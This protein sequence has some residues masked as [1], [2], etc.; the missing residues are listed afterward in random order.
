M[1]AD[2]G[3]AMSTNGEPH[4]TSAATATPVKRKRSIQD[5]KSGPEST[6]ASRES[7]N[8]HETLRSLVDLL[9]KY[10]LSKRHSKQG[11]P[12][13]NRH[14][15]EL[16]L[17]SCPFPATT[18]K[19]RTKRAKVSN[20]QD[21]SSVQ[22]R[23]KSDHYNTLQEFLAD[24][25]K[26][27]GAVIE[28]TQNQSNGNKADGT[29]LTEVVNRIA[30]FKKHMNGLVGQSFVNQTEVKTEAVDDDGDSQ[31]HSTVSNVGARE[32]KQALTFFGGSQ[33][34]PK[35]LFSSLQKSVKVPL[36][37]S[38][39]DVKKFV[40]VQEELREG[41]LPNGIT[42][43]KVIPYNLNANPKSTKRTFGEVFAP[44]AGL[45]QLEA[46]RRRTQRGTT[47][48]WIDPFDLLMD[49]KSYLGDRS[50][51]SL[52]PLPSGQWLQYG[53]VTSSP[54]YWARVEKHH[55]EGDI[56]SKHG[57]P[58][59]WTGDDSSVLQGVY[60]SFAPSYDSSGSIV[61]LDSKDMVWWGKRGAKRVRTL[62][63]LPN[64]DEEVTSVQPGSIGDLDESALDELVRSF[65]PDTVNDFINDNQTS[66]E[67]DPESREVEETLAEISDLLDTLSSYHR[68]RNLT[69]PLSA[70]DKTDSTETSAPD[71]V[72]PNTPSDAEQAIYETLKTTLMT[73]ISGLPPYAVAKLDGDQLEALNISQRIVVET[74][75]YC[76]TMERDDFTL[77][78]ERVAA[79]AAQSNAANRT[80]TPSASRPSNLGS[81]SVYNQRA[82]VSNP[83]VPQSQFQMPQHGRQPSATG[84]YTPNLSGSR[85]PGT[86]SQRSSYPAQ[87]SSQFSQANNV[88]Q[89]QRPG[90][91]GYNSYSAQQGQGQQPFTPRPGQASAYNAT[92]QGRTPYTG[93]VPAQRPP[94][95][96]QTPSQG[97]STYARSAAEQA[98]IVDRNRA[99]LAAQQSRQS[100]S[101]PQPQF[102]SRMSMSQ[103]GSLTPGSKQNGTPIL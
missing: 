2:E 66:K 13:I 10:V 36:Q 47:A 8:L 16:Q 54:S 14:D 5:D 9:L 58:A 56:G 60:S 90:P 91:N 93:G 7:P 92:P 61:Q 31:M 81:Q 102:E 103:E 30:A 20:D 17:L 97:A 44:R 1:S 46:P 85:G 86:P 51:Y 32:D 27:S 71:A 65:Q 34:N 83:R 25:E 73:I 89:F 57:D 49:T 29:P 45:P 6:S 22:S 78:Q 96:N 26:A 15:T 38:E 84:T 95:A 12:N 100:P 41:A 77:H 94:Y 39:S 76:G 42:A 68:I 37:S 62:L 72:D 63:T 80:S 40:E 24:I 11:I 75:D 52:A 21:T 74:P 67:A 59:L 99:Q 35:Q 28:R 3:T 88:P 82:L 18:A 101:T 98:A 4:S 79:I 48:S 64:E 43:T 70:S 23:V 87:G 33:S 69:L 55:T 53:G 50:N 19:P